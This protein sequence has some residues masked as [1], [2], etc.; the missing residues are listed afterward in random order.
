MVA[1]A[2]RG[3]QMQDLPEPVVVQVLSLVRDVRSRN[4]MSLVCRQWRSLE[5]QTRRSLAL[6]G[7][8]RSPWLIP[9][10]FPNVAHL[11][12]SLL[13]PW[14]HG[15]PS[16]QA[17]PQ[18]LALAFPNVASLTVYARDPSALRALAPL[19]PRLR[20]AK[21]VRW[22]RR[23]DHPPGS[24]LAPLLAACPALEALDLSEFYCWTDDV[25][26]ALLA[27]PAAAAALTRLDL[28]LASASDGFRA[29]ELSALSAACPNLRH[30]RAPCVFNP[31]FLDFVGDAALLSLAANCPRL[32]LL[33]L[34]DPS[35][36]DH[37]AD[38]DADDAR[39][40]PAGLEALFAALPAL[41]DLAL[42]LRHS[43]R[44]AGPALEALARRCPRIRALRLG[45]FHGICN[46]AWL[47]LD[48]V[49]VCG[50][51]QSLCVQDCPDLTDSALAAVARGCRRLS[52]FEIR[53]CPLVTEAGLRK[54]AAALR[55]TLKEVRISSCALLDAP[56][57][58]RAL[59]PLRDRIERLHVDCVWP[60]PDH[61]PEVP[62]PHLPPDEEGAPEAA[63]GGS[64]V[65]E[66]DPEDHRSAGRKKRRCSEEGGDE[67]EYEFEFEFEFD[68]AAN[69][70][71]VDCAYTYPWYRE[72]DRLRYLSLWLPAGEVLTPLGNAGL[73]SCP[74]L[75]E[76]CIKIEGDCRSCVRPA[77]QGF[78]LSSLVQYPKLTKMKLDCGEAIGYALTAPSGQ[79]DLS[80]WE[81]F[82]LHGIGGL[83]LYELDYWPPQDRE[84]NQRS[85]SLPATGL[86]QGCTT[87]RKLFIHGTTHE[88]FMRF[89]LLM[90]NL[91]DVQLREDYY[92]AP[93]NDMS[94]EMRVD[95]C[96]RFEEALN[97]R[98]IPD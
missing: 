2:E 70:G 76:I 30:L 22:H 48:G 39:I 93:E 37:D 80:L 47:H 90:P 68:H 52:S 98:R 26:P 57:S 61:E 75:E 41:E 45:R 23:P 11:D 24:D 4:A 40:T 83:N 25:A 20:R 9:T 55:S 66:F 27:H 13:S 54:L 73:G 15:H 35:A 78:G 31:R 74:E 16:F 79:M 71:G 50:A 14:G 6:R 59:D 3:T 43:V 51:L 19:W 34:L 46:A 96:S 28:L 8:A 60:D 36:R 69:G 94:T 32:S 92:P 67:Y 29:S 10:F 63:N 42:D 17:Q 72:W 18:P 49:A 89:F 97:S 5:R 7:H 65:D 53:G 21:L 56:R 12:L 64:E 88:H 84:V 58:L 95:S 91:R 44:G 33:H 81:R 82:Y 38:A 86:I 62:P 77:D 85:L 87:L 1:G